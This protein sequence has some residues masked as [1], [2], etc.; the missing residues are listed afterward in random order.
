MLFRGQ[1]H[2]VFNNSFTEEV[3]IPL[4]NFIL[5]HCSAGQKTPCSNCIRHGKSAIRTIA[6]HIISRFYGLLFHIYDTSSSQVRFV[7][8]ELVVKIAG[9]GN[10]FAIPVAALIGVPM[11]I[12]AET[13]I[14]ISAVL[15][16]KG[17]SMG[18]VMALVIGG[19]GASIPETIILASI[20][21]RELVISFILA[22]LAVAILAGY[23]F[24]L[25]L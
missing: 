23:F 25:V 24:D 1:G 16:D 12:R 15:L 9:T 13:I 3:A 6:H 14:P 5:W 2:P 8:E 18:A 22:V 21:R 10:P 7:P 20:F 19:A 17:M 4:F 11:Y